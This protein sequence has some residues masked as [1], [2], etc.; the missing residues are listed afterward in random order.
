MTIA[1]SAE[2]GQW[3]VLAV[4]LRD[5]VGN[6]ATLSTAA[7]QTLGFPI[8]LI[9]TSANSDTVAPSLVAFELSPTQVNVASGP[10]N[11]MVTLHITD[12]GTGFNWGWVELVSPSGQQTS[13]SSIDPA[14][15]SGT[16]NDG[17]FQ[18]QMTIAKSAE[19]GQW[20]V[21]A[22]ALRD[23]VGN[24]ATL[25]T[26]A[27]QTMG[28]PITL[29]VGTNVTVAPKPLL[30]SLTPNVSSGSNQV[31]TITYNSPAGYQ[32]LDVV[33]VLINTFLDG[34]QACYLAYSRPSNVLYI[35]PDNGDGTELSGK[36]MAGMGTVGN[37]Q[38]TVMLA[39]SSATGN[40]TALTLVL[41][42]SFSASSFGGN[43][44][45]YA[46]ARD[47]AQNNSG[48]QTMGVVG[49]PP[50]PS[51]FPNPTGM[52]PSSGSSL[53]ATIAFTYQDQS[54]AANLQ[55]VWALINTAIDGRAACYVAYYRPG[56]QLYLYPDNGDGTQAS[57][58]VLTGN[59][60]I[61]NSQC[62]VS[63]QGANLQ[64]SGNTLTVSLPITF[65]PSFA[66]FKGAWL[67]AQS[68]GGAQTSPWQAFGAEVVPAQ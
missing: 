56:N 40:G 54:T 68:M 32:A 44:V 19:Q 25:S 4:A 65:K 13:T 26:A 33:N 51:T 10:A 41:N 63:A 34:R 62:T 15:L 17:I 16:T 1:K 38:C 14:P 37:S 29:Q 27:L 5:V 52:N 45:I 21:S 11:V 64:T 59:N 42:L 22:V 6:T 20:Q 9:V 39:G 7:L 58:I 8:T 43:K 35:V 48:W 30:V 36:V 66:G 49:V 57:N 67:A 18:A 31:F 3:Q 50:L 55:T 60:T 47:I 23:V 46:A 53:T 61:S 12:A 28:F 24:T 2:Q